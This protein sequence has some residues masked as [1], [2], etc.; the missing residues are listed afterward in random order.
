[1]PQRPLEARDPV[2][3][4]AKQPGEALRAR[5]RFRRATAADVPGLVPVINDAYVP[6]D[7]WLFPGQV[8]T[9]DADL[10]DAL[11]DPNA[12]I[13]V[14]EV[15]RAIAASVHVAYSGTDAKFSMLATAPE[16][17]GRGIARLLLEYIEREARERGCAEMHLTCIRDTG[18]PPFYQSAGYV[19]TQELAIPAGEGDFGTAI[20]PWTKVRMKKELR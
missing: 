15:D 17:Q 16:M 3:A 7:G 1:M 10:L 11:R 13:M 12:D 6:R 18:L 20:Q 8:R 9:D 2:A 5:V 19:V 14:A 4:R